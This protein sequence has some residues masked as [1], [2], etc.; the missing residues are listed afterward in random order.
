MPV[1]RLLFIDIINFY[2]PQLVMFELAETTVK[3]V[4]GDCVI[5]WYWKLELL[6]LILVFCCNYVFDCSLCEIYC[7]FMEQAGLPLNFLLIHVT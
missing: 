2:P 5:I 7:L 1:G 3:V 6:D 4:V